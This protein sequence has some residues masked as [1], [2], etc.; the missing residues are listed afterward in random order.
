MN[1]N[2]FANVFR[3]AFLKDVLQHAVYIPKKHDNL[4]LPP[5]VNLFLDALNKFLYLNGCAPILYQ[6]YLID[7][8]KL[9]EYALFLRGYMRDAQ[10]ILATLSK[11]HTT[12]PHLIDLFKASSEYVVACNHQFGNK[13][14]FDNN[15]SYRLWK[16]HQPN[17]LSQAEYT[18][19]EGHINPCKH[20][21]FLFM[22][23]RIKDNQ[24]EVQKWVLN[25][26]RTTLN[27]RRIFGS[28]VDVY[29]QHFPIQKSRSSNIYS[30][31]ETLKTP[32]TYYDEK[33]L[34]FVC[35]NWLKFVKKD[36]TAEKNTH[37]LY[38]EE[39]LYR[40]F[41]N[42][43]IFAYCSGAANA[44]RVLNALYDVTRQLY[45]TETAQNAMKQIGVITYGFLPIQEHSLY[46]GIHFYTN[47]VADTNRREPFVN[48]NNHLLYEET[49]CKSPLL[50]A[51]YSVMP[52]GRN[53]IIALR[54]P[55]QMSIIKDNHPL[56]FKDSEFGHSMNFI[57]QTNLLDDKN[58]SYHIFCDT[59][60]KFS[61]GKRDFNDICPAANNTADNLI[62]HSL[63]KSRMQKI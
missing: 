39:E 23:F 15:T 20:N 59:L 10:P 3:E 13:K 17:N 32:E 34:E 24:T 16:L 44:H 2:P 42:L 46:S 37:N 18:R 63:L 35:Q 30:L 4:S 56:L 29:V 14:F 33:D 5:R 26:M 54:M 43:T 62:T 12:D 19:A 36:P 27:N 21:L 52:D 25:N 49:K 1:N 51:N 47:A 8:P 61:L 50:P 45:G 38:K 9:L 7:E 22:P 57:N 53:F 40:N 58:Y 41:N 55:E 60:Q 31:L 28:Q 48:L 11:Q 6:K